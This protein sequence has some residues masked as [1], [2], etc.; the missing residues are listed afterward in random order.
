MKR[1]YKEYCKRGVQPMLKK[2]GQFPYEVYEDGVASNICACT[3]CGRLMKQ[4]T[5]DVIAPTGA[6]Y[7]WCPTCCHAQYSDIYRVYK[8][9]RK[10]PLMEQTTYEKEIAQILR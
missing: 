2:V 1:H 4:R 6:P 3:I 5:I 10:Y 8:D 9:A 7:M